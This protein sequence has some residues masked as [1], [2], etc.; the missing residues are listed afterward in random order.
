MS[1]NTQVTA[2]Q[3][4]R[5][6]SYAEVAG[7]TLLLYDHFLMLDGEVKYIWP[8]RLSLVTFLYYV[9]K[10]S[11]FLYVLIICFRKSYPPRSAL[12]IMSRGIPG[13]YLPTSILHT[14]CR[15]ITILAGWTHIVG[16]SAAE[17]IL[18]TKAWAVWAESKKMRILIMIA[19]FVFL[20]ASY[21]FLELFVESLRFDIEPS[22]L[23]DSNMKGCIAIAVDP[24]YNIIDWVILMVFDA[25]VT[26]LLVFRGLQAYG[27]GGN[28]ELFRVI[29]RDGL[30]F[31][32]LAT[33]VSLV[34]AVLMS[35]LSSGL[36]LLLL[37][38]SR[39]LHVNLTSR[40]VLR[41]RQLIEQSV[42]RFD[43]CGQELPT[44][45]TSLY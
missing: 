2:F 12:H 10:Y 38:P 35:S 15:G 18:A 40:I 25:F 4:A 36:V 30:I 32:I 11:C 29:Y 31:Y 37:F 27:L 6:T 9:S 44:C 21:P 22:L 20:T 26:L 24:R 45:D 33:A 23:D 14:H 43:N 42:H 28:S 17:G 41:T 3:D 13:T 5:I 16:L 1:S 34:T 7:L 19:F 39:V 8:S